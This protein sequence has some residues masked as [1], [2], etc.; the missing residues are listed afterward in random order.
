M[1]EVREDALAEIGLGYPMLRATLRELD[2][3]L[4]PWG[5]RE[6]GRCLLAGESRDRRPGKWR[7]RST[8]GAGD[9]AQEILET[10]QAADASADD[11]GAEAR[12][13]RQ[14]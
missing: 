10:P 11:P 3:A 6:G 14:N 8:A 5:D 9:R 4:S 13:G 2:A 1:A 7:P 12:N